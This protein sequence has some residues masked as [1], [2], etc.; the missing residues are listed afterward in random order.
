MSEDLW[1]RVNNDQAHPVT[2]GLQTRMYKDSKGTSPDHSGSIKETA[3]GKRE[4]CQERCKKEICKNPEGKK[5]RQESK[6][7]TELI[8]ADGKWLVNT[9]KQASA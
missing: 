9:L 3:D 7:G 2:H 6:K 8:A 1:W 4:K 5:E